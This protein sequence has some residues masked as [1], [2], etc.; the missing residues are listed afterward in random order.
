MPQIRGKV[1]RYKE[2]ELTYFNEK[3][4]KITKKLNGFFARLIQHECDHLEG[5]VFLEKVKGHSGCAT[6][7]NINKYKLREK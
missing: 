7:E 2:I 1:E 5:I 6:L 3:G 4:E